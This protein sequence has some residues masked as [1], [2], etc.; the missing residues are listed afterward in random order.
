[1]QRKIA[2]SGALMLAMVW[3]LAAQ[4]SSQQALDK[5]CFSCHGA[6]LR[7]E[8][9]SFERLA[10]KLAKLKGNP[11][12]EQQF[13]SEFQ[14]GE[15]LNHIPVHERLSPASAKALVHWLVDGAP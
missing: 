6:N 4:A 14:A 2:F 7:G 3:P 13:V 11:A 5:G 9:P 12:A 8:A 1:M 10:S 15:I